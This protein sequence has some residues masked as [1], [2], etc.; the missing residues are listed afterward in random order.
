[1]SENA[2]FRMGMVGCGAISN[3][4]AHAAQNSHENI[5]FVS[6]C[7]IVPGTAEAWAARYDCPS[8]YVD[9]EEMICRED[10]DGV[11]LATWPN[12]HREQIEKCLAAGAKN[13]LC[14]KALTLT[15]AEAVQIN[16]MVTQAGAFLMEGFMYRHHPAI[17]KLEELLSVGDVGE[18]DNVRACFSNYD[19][20]S[21]SGDDATRNW[22]QR[23]ECGGGIPY[24]FACYCVNACSH[25][26]ASLPKRV[27]CHG[28][29]SEKYGLV[30]RLYALIEYE[31]GCVGIV[32]SSKRAAFTQELQITGANAILNLPIAWT[33]PDEALI[34]RISSPRWAVLDEQTYPIGAADAY[35]LQ[36]ENFAAVVRRVDQPT[37]PLIE[38]VVNCFT[39]ETIVTSLMQREV[40]DIEIPQAVRTAWTAERSS[41]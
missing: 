33:I 29:I 18:V 41:R 31:N 21:A 12:Q 26:A 2:E 36:I 23:K 13:I 14:E 37:I 24:D 9:Y 39:T 16:E 11:L 6:C 1:V 15:A 30:N 7:D 5:R 35:Q 17:G 40:V 8:T 22:R 20:E 38:S 27:Y 34:K 25:F 19:D 3:A 32:E 28:N 10:L 4:H